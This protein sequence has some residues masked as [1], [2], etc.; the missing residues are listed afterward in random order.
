M[1]AFWAIE[2][3]KNCETR[4]PLVP[5]A[6]PARKKPNELIAACK[7]RGLLPFANF[8]RIHVAPPLNVSTAD[9]Q[10]GLAI[11]DEALAVADAA[12]G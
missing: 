3:V 8:N 12:I 1:G 2:L 7:S 10:A 5:T 11:L 6:A 4:E 9:A